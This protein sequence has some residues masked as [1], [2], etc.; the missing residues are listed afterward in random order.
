MAETKNLKGEGKNM[1]SR[2][3]QNRPKPGLVF[4]PDVDIFESEDRP[5]TAGG[6]A[7]CHVRQHYH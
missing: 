4:T 5:Y 1:S 7:G 2:A 3:L 6:Y